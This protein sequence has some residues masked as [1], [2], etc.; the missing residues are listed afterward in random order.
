MQLQFIL[1][2]SGSGKS[3]ELSEYIIREAGKEPMQNFLILVPEQFTLQTQKEYVMHHP[4]HGIM[5]IDVASFLRL[6]HHVFAEVG[7]TPPLVLE[8]MGKSLIVKKLLME[9]KSELMQY[10]P[11]INKQ[12]FIDEMK[13]VISEF[14]QYSIDQD[15]FDRM[16]DAA[17]DRPVL[18]RKLQDI[19]IIQ[20]AFSDFLEE[21][22]IT[23]EEIL[24]LL[25]YEIEKSEKIANSTIV[26]DGFTGFTPSQYGLLQKL[27]KHSRRMLVTVTMDRREAFR[28]QK[29]HQLFYLSRKTIETLTELAGEV[30]CEVADPWLFPVKEDRN[31]G[32]RRFA[33]SEALAALEKNIYRYPIIPYEKETD[34]IKIFA[35]RDAEDEIKLAVSL[36]K[37]LIREKQWHYR[38]IAIVCG[39]IGIYGSRLQTVFDEAKIPCFVDEKKGIIGN[40]MS[41]LLRSL[42]SIAEENYSYEAVFRYIKSGLSD[43]TPK[44][45]DLMEEYVI[46]AGIRGRNRWGKDWEVR[47]D[48]IYKIDIDVL[49][50]LRNKVFSAVSPVAEVLSRSD[51]TVKERVTILYDFFEK[52]NIEQKMIQ[53][54]A[55]LESETELL[56]VKHKALL[57]K[58]Y[59]QV[60][61]LIM[62]IFDR[63]YEL[64]FD[65][66]VSV[67]EFRE[68]METG[69]KEA[70]VGLIPPGVDQIVVGDVERTRLMGIRALFFVG[71]NDGYVPKASNS[72]GLLTDMDRRVFAEQGIELSPTRRQSAYTG[73]FYLY[74][75]LTKPSK[76]LYMFYSEYSNDGKKI[77]PS[78]LLARIGKLFPKLTVQDDRRDIYYDSMMGIDEGISALTDAVRAYRDEKEEAHFREMYLAIA[79]S[80]KYPYLTAKQLADNAFYKPEEQELSRKMAIRLYGELL[81]GSISRLEQYAACAYAHF[82]QYGLQ[83][84]KRKEYEILLPDIGTIFHNALDLFSNKLKKSEYSW[85][86][87]TEQVRREFGD[88]SVL[89]AVTGYK[90]ELLTSTSRRAYLI[91][92]INRILQRA[93][94]TIQEQ[95]CQGSFTPAAYEKNF[96]YADRYL[97]LR[98]RIDRVD[99]IKKDG[100]LYLSVIDYKSGSTVF[101]MNKLY[102]GLQLQ[103][104]VYLKEAIRMMEQT[105]KDAEPVPAGIFYYRLE[106]PMVSKSE[107]AE[108]D[109]RKEL[110][111]NG[112]VNHDEGILP[113]LDEGFATEEGGLAASH[114]SLVIPAETKRDGTLTASSMTASTQQFSDVM[115]YLDEMMHRF[116]REIM[117]GNAAM[118]PVRYKN[119]VT[120]SYCDFSSICCFDEVR[121][122]KCR[123]I[124][125]LSQD[126]I[127][128]MIADETKQK[129]Q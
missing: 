58:E 7:K 55:E 14:Y 2:S 3:Y 42:L 46:A 66:V 21:R 111:M 34:D 112:L 54:A 106:D 60:Y 124:K 89:E 8:D 27:M 117:D 80:G 61:R 101:D 38:D 72:G 17:K 116:G 37:Q 84:S 1:G 129:E 24:D 105:V 49:N 110:R 18:L 104:G 108:Q 16:L 69:L 67:R 5:N 25:S 107:H 76:K 98:G 22:F 30:G 92:R 35:A 63:C 85:K 51:T 53:K 70:K 40:P 119:T 45:S 13:S 97:A 73:E 20:K 77:R 122:K 99:T 128:R 82:L 64:L 23:T 28:M 50:N 109:I 71:V 41:E 74:L 57:I 10:A 79:Q 96:E 123:N 15:R 120:C 102:H 86:T 127:L 68:I 26:L 6:A 44:E 9:K 118:N 56:L 31:H 88:E 59:E 19:H 100:K 4:T 83:L 39:D 32:N 125:K 36:V 78:S 81:P 126:D 114:Q 95:I 90:A 115:T 43:I 47:K 87:M 93:V 103:L 121:M 75:N 29:E 11:N 48:S 91:N 113:L 65:Q 52:Y 94:K 33:D 12:G 62:D